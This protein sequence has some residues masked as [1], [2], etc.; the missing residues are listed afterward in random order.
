MF[1]QIKTQLSSDCDQSVATLKRKGQNMLFLNQL[2][3]SLKYNVT[4]CKAPFD[5]SNVS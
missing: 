1:D 3:I 4:N 5:L 2:D